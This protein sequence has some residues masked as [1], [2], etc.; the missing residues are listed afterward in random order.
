ML[1]IIN[2]IA[3]GLVLTSMAL[4]TSSCQDFLEE[5]PQTSLSI[6]QVFSDKKNIQPYLNGLYVKFRE[7][8]SG[9]VGLRLNHGT[10]EMKV[11]EKQHEDLSKGA[12]DDFSA[13][14]NSENPYFSELWNLRWPVIVKA[15]QARQVLE[16]MVAAAGDNDEE[17]KSY[18]GQAA[19]YEA[20]GL[21]EVTMY[22]GEIPL[23]QINSDGSITLT[24]RRPLNEVYK[25]MEDL[26]K[27]AISNLPSTRQ[28]DGR[29]PTIWTA[30]AML[31]KLYMGAET[32]EYRNYEEAATLLSDIVTNGGFRLVSNYADLWNYSKS[33]DSESL[34]TFYFNNTTDVHHL[35]WY[36]GSRASSG[37][38]QRCPWGGYDEAV[39]TAYAYNTQN[40]GGVW[41][42][43]DT[44]KDATLRFVFNWD[45]QVASATPGFGNDQLDPHIKKYEDNRIIELDK[46]FWDCG[47]NTYY[48]RYA[49]VLMLYAE[50]LNE[51]GRTSEAVTL[52]N[53]TVR[54]RAWGGTLPAEMKWNTGMSQDEFRTKILDERMRELMCELWRRY[55]LLRTGKYVEY[56][57]QRNPWAK[58]SGNMQSY[59]KRFPIPYTE[60]TQNENISV[61]DQNPGLK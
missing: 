59:H 38:G 40:N 60:I 3:V 29:V 14:Y 23:T 22:W 25:H 6:E 48:L 57:S 17:L 54:T 46:T 37:W 5:D 41:E 2:K 56:T 16:S 19:F 21:F 36:C 47:N 9:R 53:E 13:L 20:T 32:P 1:T 55:D 12:F 4:L 18:L 8:R 33:A 11:G 44:R 28:A 61:D 30:K 58:E 45:G 35:Q 15:A 24:G 7:S 39:P 43:G 26:Y 49:D 52:I 34:W 31:A 51:L 27:V 10:D 50:A 42:D